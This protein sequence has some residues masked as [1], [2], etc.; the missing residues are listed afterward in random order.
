M[1]YALLPVRLCL[2]LLAPAAAT[3][4]T[5][6]VTPP[7]SVRLQGSWAMVSGAANGAAGAV[8]PRHGADHER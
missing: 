8:R 4:Q 2:G 1:R 6:G 3:G 7:D 5:A